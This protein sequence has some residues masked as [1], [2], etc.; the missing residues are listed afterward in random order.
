[1][2]ESKTPRTDAAEFFIGFNPDEGEMVVPSEKVRQLE[3]ELSEANY[4][5][6]LQTT[7]FEQTRQDRDQWKK[8]AEKAEAG[9]ADWQQIAER[10]NILLI[11]S[12]S[13]L[14]CENCTNNLLCDECQG[15]KNLMDKALS[16]FNAMKKGKV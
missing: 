3:T 13:W 5:I 15:Q 6:K 16:D 2:N 7:G 12:Y 8:R 11:H 1:M 9:L 14:G 4:F 10:L